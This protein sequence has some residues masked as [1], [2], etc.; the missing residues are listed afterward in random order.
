MTSLVRKF[1]PEL[2]G[3]RAHRYVEEI[4]RHHRIQASPGF[5]AAANWC[6]EQLLAAGVS[7]EILEYAADR[8][9][10]YWSLPGF[11]EWS[12]EEAE[13][14]LIEP[15]GDRRRLCDYRDEKLSLVQR[16]LSTP[17]EGV[18]AEL[19]VLDKAD[20]EESYW[21]LDV[22]GKVLLV[23]GDFRRIHP[24]AVEKHGALGLVTDAMMEQP[25]VR[26]RT[27]LP[28]ALQYM[29]F[30]WVSGN[31]KGFGFVVS[32][33]V[34]AA[35]REKAK[36]LSEET[37]ARRLRVWAKVRSRLYDGQFENVTAVIPG[38][39]PE[40]VLVIAHLCHPQPSA[41]DN[42]S[43]AAVAMEVAMTLARLI[44]DGKLAQPRRTIRFLW[45]PEMTGTFAYL[46]SR[47]ADAPRIIAAVNLDMVGENQDL[48][49]S[50]L[51]VEHPPRACPSFAGDLLTQI[52]KATTT[53]PELEGNTPSLGS[54]TAY[55]LF[56]WAITPYS[57]GSDHFI[58]SDPTVGIPCPMLIQ[59]P[60]KYYHTSEDTPDKVDPRMLHRVGILAATYTWFLAN[61]GYPEAV[62]LAG[63]IA[64]GFGP[65]IHS[66][67]H[68]LLHEGMKRARNSVT[69]R[70]IVNATDSSASVSETPGLALA[71]MLSGIRKQLSFLVERKRADLRSIDRLLRTAEHEFF[72]LIL[73][74]LD[75]ELLDQV[76][77]EECRLR[78]VLRGIRA[79]LGDCTIPEIP[80]RQL[81]EWETKAS[82]MIPRRIHPGPIMWNWYL[83]RLNETLSAEFKALA[84]KHQTVNV[85]TL[86]NLLDYWIDGKRSLLQVVDLVEL[87]SGIRDPHLAV[88]YVEALESLGLAEV[89][90]SG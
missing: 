86:L 71:E 41:N 69:N 62:W 48:T 90:A 4:A 54:R 26:E 78:L 66:K 52:L 61:A 77:H 76:N 13:L 63:E 70:D 47:P 46:S 64:A 85:G 53:D 27:D 82:A 57:G 42:A 40:E 44:A 50:T 19:L 35:L 68:D 67:V 36:K 87:E 56:R 75:Q 8:E 89:A 20:A 34:G 24:L 37:P 39:T 16:S 45:V 84:K 18:E 14:W 23:R 5:R 32:P 22:A 74:H 9:T 59:W 2:S 7:T 30:H 49:K 55:P 6:L 58:L 38:D 25:P 83:G 29:T 51:C 33:R 21:G 3:G 43:G 28:D 1:A 88:L 72:D 80:P 60:D 81:D 73:H 15:S 10:N 17:A 65:A 12:A 79:T 11:Q 31:P